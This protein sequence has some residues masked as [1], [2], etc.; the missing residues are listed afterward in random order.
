MTLLR[1]RPLLILRITESRA[2]MLEARAAYDTAASDDPD[3]IGA[4]HTAYERRR[5][6]YIAALERLAAAV[7][8]EEEGDL[9]MQ[10][11][12]ML[13]LRRDVAAHTAANDPRII[14]PD[15]SAVL[16]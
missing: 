2:A 4:T 11:E 6:E 8:A 14:V 13:E 9:E 15:V 12:I 1:P 10:M 3:A 16:P 5:D 7:Q